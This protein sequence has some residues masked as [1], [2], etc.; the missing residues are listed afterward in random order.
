MKF[1]NIKKKAKVIKSPSNSRSIAEKSIKSNFHFPKISHT[2]LINV[3]RGSLKVFLFF[4]FI[5]AATVVGMD[6]KK[7]LQMKQ[8]I[9]SQRMTLEKNL[10]FWENFIL[11]HQDYRDAYIQA[12]II[13][14][15]LG[16]TPKARMYVENSLVL[17]PNSSE[18]LKVEQLLK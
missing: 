11:K 10:N 7:N 3:Y 18:G 1:K 12:S 9:D 15:K 17:D 4:V 16:N 6:F 5:L 13:E 14:Y 2:T 8:N